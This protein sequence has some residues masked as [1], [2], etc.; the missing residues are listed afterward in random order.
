MA[1][2]ARLAAIGTLA[3]LIAGLFGVS[4]GG[5]IVPLLVLWAGYGE[6]RAAAASLGA[7]VPI[8]ATAAIAHGVYGNVD[9]G[10]A[11]LVGLPAVG[12]VVVG[13][14]LSR[15]VPAPAIRVVFAVLLIAVAARL[16]LS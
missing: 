11:A 4:G 10:K 1:P 8:A 6:R 12:G 9:V 2:R 7:I 5:F 15:R 16:A 3:G 13:T 14:G